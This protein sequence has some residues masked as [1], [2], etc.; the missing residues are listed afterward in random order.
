M[1]IITKGL[2]YGGDQSFLGG[3]V[4]KIS[5]SSS[6]CFKWNHIS[7]D[8]LVDKHYIRR[9]KFKR[10][11]NFVK[12]LI[13]CVETEIFSLFFYAKLTILDIYSSA[14]F[15]ALIFELF[16]MNRIIARSLRRIIS[17]IKSHTIWLIS[18]RLAAMIKIKGKPY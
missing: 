17:L 4:S 5:Q 9:R 12:C 13:I 8:L 6:L 7:F 14:I 11:S 16:S 3:K 10:Y 18:R 1:K 15:V 2:Q